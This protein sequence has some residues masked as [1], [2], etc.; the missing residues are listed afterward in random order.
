LFTN[1]DND[2]F[3]VWAI[4]EAYGIR[5]DV[6]LVN[7]SLVNTDWYIKQLKK[8]EPRVPISFSDAFIENQL[9]PEYN[10][11]ESPMAVDLTS[12]KLRGVIPGRKDLQVLRVQDKMIL[13]IIHATDWSK[14]VYFAA[15]VSSDNF[16]GLDHYLKM[17]G[18][19]WRLM[20]ERVPENERIDAER[21]GILLDNVY[22]IRSLPRHIIDK[23][24]PYAGIVNDYTVCFLYYAMAL[25]E[26]LAALDKEIASLETA[27]ASPEKNVRADSA[28]L[29]GKR[30]LFRAGF[31]RVVGKLDRCVSLMPWNMQPVHYRHEFLMKFRE[32]KMAEERVQKLLLID[33]SDA[34]LRKFLAQALDA[35][36]KRK[37]A[38]EIL[39]KG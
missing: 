26:R 7:L 8:L 12:K 34:Q 15:S 13:N 22:R 31:D 10:P 6:R 5:R 27:A 18:M 14:P 19:A 9:R 2:T 30:A 25:Q 3:P 36:G 4:Q 16:M 29:A 23:D 20:P 35:Q 32:P 28:A 38:M 33:P 37:E 11:L 39:R 17:E 21:I 24:E 1:G